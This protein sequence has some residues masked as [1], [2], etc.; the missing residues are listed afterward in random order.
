MTQPER[1]PGPSQ[2][3]VDRARDALAQTHKKDEEDAADG[4][5]RDAATDPGAGDADS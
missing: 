1:D 3:Q 5:T 4:T 2:Q